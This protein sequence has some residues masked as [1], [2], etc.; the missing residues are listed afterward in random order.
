MQTFRKIRTLALTSTVISLGTLFATAAIAGA[1]RPQEGR[2]LS[3]LV[4]FALLVAFFLAELW[5]A[6]SRRRIAARRSAGARPRS[7]RGPDGLG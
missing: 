5:W 2:D 6:T 3:L 7:G 1:G 4:P